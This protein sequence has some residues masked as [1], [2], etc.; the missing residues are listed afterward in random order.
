LPLARERKLAVIINRPFAEGAL[1]RKVR[2]K[3]L[4]PWAKNELGIQSW[5][6]FFLKWIVGHPA[7]TCA[8][9]GTGK[10]EHMRDNLGAATGPLPDAGQRTRMAQYLEKL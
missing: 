7:V 8:I 1:F 4:P 10:P 5:A 9:P 2:G 6:Q 3:P